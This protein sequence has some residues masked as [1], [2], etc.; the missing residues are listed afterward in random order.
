MRRSSDAEIRDAEIRDAEIRA[1]EIRAAEIGDQSL[2]PEGS[3]QGMPSGI[4]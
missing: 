1:E 4:P 2:Y 3:Y